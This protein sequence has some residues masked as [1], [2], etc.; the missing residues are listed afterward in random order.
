MPSLD[1]ALADAS[2][3]AGALGL[4]LRT[5]SLEQEVTF[6]KY[7]RAV[8]P[9]DGFVFWVNAALL[10]DQSIWAATGKP[11]G[12]GAR[13][14]CVKGSLHMGSTAQQLEDE[15]LA[16]NAVVF[17][18]QDPIQDLA[19]PETG[20]L[21]LGSF[22]PPG[23]LPDGEA[24]AP[25][26]FAFS[27]TAPF[28]STAKLWHYRG[29][30][31]YPAFE[32]QFIDSAADFDLT[33]V[34]VSNSLPVWLTIAST[35]P[36]FWAPPRNLFPAY[37]SFLVPD[38]QTPPYASVHI[39][40]S[41][42]RAIQATLYLDQQL[43]AFQ[44]AHD[45]VRFTFYGLRNDDVMD[46]VRAVNQY[47]VDNDVIGIVN[48]PIVVDEKRQQNEISAI[49]MKKTVTFEVTYYQTRLTDVARQL[50]KKVI[51][52]VTPGTQPV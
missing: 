10:S 11:A 41:S 43:D 12:E 39:E 24:V 7:V 42:T 21:W 44:L 29:D 8:L 16:I 34:V 15:Q 33:N 19:A 47:S 51:A 27:R 9:L 1:E 48:M 37:P 31:V 23:I 52:T 30:A 35:A 40:P 36:P 50:I 20:V 4:G 18:T 6:I 49:A 32:S 3:A 17:T 28:Y 2:Q 13:P 25:V 46:F 14:L 26:R 5:V 22:T 45:T 38:N